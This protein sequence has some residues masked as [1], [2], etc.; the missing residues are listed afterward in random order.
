MSDYDE[1]YNNGYGDAQDRYMAYI[2]DYVAVLRTE[3]EKRENEFHG[4]ATSDTSIYQKTGVLD[5]LV[6]KI[7]G[8][9]LAIRLAEER[10]Q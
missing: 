5:H 10:M 7:S 3:L 4:V 6:G 8:L 9:K 1:G 2:N